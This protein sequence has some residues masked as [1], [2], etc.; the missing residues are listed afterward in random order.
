VDALEKKLAQK[1]AVIAE[2]TQEYVLAK[3]GFFWEFR[4]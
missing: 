2:V 3:K 1:D 4:G